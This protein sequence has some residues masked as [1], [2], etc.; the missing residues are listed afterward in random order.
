[1][2]VV[3]EKTEFEVSHVKIFLNAKGTTALQLMHALVNLNKVITLIEVLLINHSFI[4]LF[5]FY[6]DTDVR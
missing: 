6:S 5:N 2:E 4:V 1:M 3:T